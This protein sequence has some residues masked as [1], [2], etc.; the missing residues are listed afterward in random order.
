MIQE[1]QLGSDTGDSL[2]EYCDGTGGRMDE[3][4]NQ[5]RGRKGRQGERCFGFRPLALTIGGFGSRRLA[6]EQA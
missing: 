4:E 5:W 3:C 2:G 1:S 6:T